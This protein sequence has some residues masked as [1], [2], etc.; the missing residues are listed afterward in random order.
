MLSRRPDR[1]DIREQPM[2]LFETGDRKQLRCE[3]NGHP[4]DMNESGS[5]AA[6]A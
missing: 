5:A 6:R 1:A 3:T 4:A 2:D